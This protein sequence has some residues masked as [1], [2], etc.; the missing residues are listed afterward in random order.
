MRG[1][2]KIGLLSLL[3]VAAVFIRNAPAT[4]ILPYSTYGDLYGWQGNR[5]YEEN[6]FNVLIDFTVYDTSTYPDEFVGA[7]GF[8]NPGTGQY[9]YAYQIFNHPAADEDIMYFGIFGIDGATID[10][11]T[12]DGLSSQDDGEA[13]VATSDEYFDADQ[14]RVV[15]QF[16]WGVLIAGK[17]SYFLV[18]S[19]DDVPVVG[20]YE[21]RGFEEEG[22]PPTPAPEPSTLIL[23]GLS[24]A[25]MF[26]R[27]RN[28]I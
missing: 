15:W 26:M 7:D 24:S 10:E 9:I 18:F 14:A 16:D 22:E 21:I 5:I 3:L 28:S 19:S 12:I 1:I 6:G 27:R 13:G 20:D 8:V 2:R 4:L 23:L 25:L 17:H 11:A